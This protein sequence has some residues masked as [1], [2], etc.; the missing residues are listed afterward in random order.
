MLSATC[1][2]PRNLPATTSVTCPVAKFLSLSSSTVP[3]VSSSNLLLRS[4]LRV[5]YHSGALAT[6]NQSI[7]YNLLIEIT[8]LANGIR[9][10]TEKTLA[11]TASVGVYVGAGSR[12]DTLATSGVSHVLRNMLTRGTT[13]HSRTDFNNEIQSLG[14]RLHGESGREQ[15]SL[16]MTVFKNDVPRAVKLLGDCISN[17]RNDPAELEILK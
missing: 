17:A 5:C 9:V 10:A 3:L 2:S 13:S 12:N 1:S 14:A 11:S 6:Q 4:V 7:Y 8:T 16:G 15:T